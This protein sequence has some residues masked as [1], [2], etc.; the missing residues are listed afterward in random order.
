MKCWITLDL[1]E[2][3]QTRCDIS[4]HGDSDPFLSLGREPDS[5][6]GLRAVSL[7][8]VWE[9]C[10]TQ[11][12]KSFWSWLNLAF[13][14]LQGLLPCHRRKLNLVWL[15]SWQ[16]PLICNS[17]SCFPNVYKL[18]VGLLLLKHSQGLMGN[19]FVCHF[20]VSLPPFK[21]SHCIF[22]GWYNSHLPWALSNNCWRWLL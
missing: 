13:P 10:V 18:S 12:Q 15:D 19:W 3:L 8:C 1:R 16:I 9:C 5:F 6:A 11:H 2:S 20:P 7:V 21:D 14:Y 17:T 4:F 22:H